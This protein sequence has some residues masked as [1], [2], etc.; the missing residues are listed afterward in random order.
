M[1]EKKEHAT[2]DD[3]MGLIGSKKTTS[4][5]PTTNRVQDYNN[6][7]LTDKQNQAL[8]AEVASYPESV[9]NGARALYANLVKASSE[10]SQFASQGFKQSLSGNTADNAVISAYL[11]KHWH[12]A[13]MDK[14]ANDIPELLDSY[15]KLNDYIKA[16]SQP[17]ILREFA[18]HYLRGMALSYTGFLTQQAPESKEAV[19]QKLKGIEKMCRKILLIKDTAATT[20]EPQQ[21]AKATLTQSSDFAS[22]VQGYG[23]TIEQVMQDMGD[24]EATKFYKQDK[25]AFLTIANVFYRGLLKVK[26]GMQSGADADFD[27]DIKALLAVVKESAGFVPAEAPDY[28]TA[29]L[30]VVLSVFVRWD[31]AD[32][33]AG[34]RIAFIQM[35]KQLFETVRANA[36]KELVDGYTTKLEKDI[37]SALTWFDT[38]RISSPEFLAI[39]LAANN[40]FKEDVNG[41]FFQRHRNQLPDTADTTFGK[42]MF[43]AGFGIMH[44]A[45]N[46]GANHLAPVFEG[47][48][49]ISDW[50]AKQPESKELFEFMSVPFNI[51]DNTDEKFRTPSF[52]MAFQ[53]ATVYAKGRFRES[54]GESFNDPMAEALAAMDKLTEGLAQMPGI[55]PADIAKL[56]ELS[57]KGKN[58]N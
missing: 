7:V 1:F 52:D 8:I 15:A 44:I 21:A 16:Q 38:C 55:D 20:Q 34:E 13:V 56:R 45:M 28:L 35:G 2:Q 32:L 23:T 54:K 36:I 12:T 24:K 43:Y 27:L 18:G 17:E 30:N 10:N 46:G 25:V 40:F 57:N 41:Q 33:K 39:K 3:V 9:L 49:E 19:Q 42:A 29:V 48:N 58:S 50:I 11:F 53:K 22:A 26:A 47:F 14:G 51:I 31:T 4:Q 37:P 5:E 6:Q